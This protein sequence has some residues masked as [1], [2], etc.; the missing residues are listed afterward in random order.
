[1][2]GSALGSGGA[3]APPTTLVVD[4]SA[5]KLPCVMKYRIRGREITPAFSSVAAGHAFQVEIIKGAKH[6]AKITADDNLI[7]DVKVVKDDTTLRIE[8]D[9]KNKSFR[10]VHWKATVTMPKLE[11]IHLDGACHATVEGFDKVKT[12]TAKLNG[13]SHLTGTVKLV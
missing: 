12:L 3:S 8:V 5:R 6:S 10:D 2:P 1:M 11:A 13:A 9:T 7:D 4:W